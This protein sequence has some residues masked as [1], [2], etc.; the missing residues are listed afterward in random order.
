M[1]AVGEA[2]AEGEEAA[3]VG[4]EGEEAAEAGVLREPQLKAAGEAGEGV[5]ERVEFWLGIFAVPDFLGDF[6][7]TFGSGFPGEFSTV[8]EFPRLGS[9]PASCGFPASGEF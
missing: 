9:F 5:G 2:A 6:R 8:G 3:E 1:K 7:V 4:A